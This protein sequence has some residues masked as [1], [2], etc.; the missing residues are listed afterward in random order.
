MNQ[1]ESIAERRNTA[2]GSAMSK[3]RNI[4]KANGVNRDSLKEVR[5]VLLGLA[6][7]RE[8]F[9]EADFPS[10][11]GD[12]LLY[13]LSEDEDDRFALYLSTG[14]PGRSSP[15][16]NHTTWAVIVGIEGEE[17]NRMY[18]RVDDGSEPGR[19]EVRMRDE[20]VVKE[21]TGICFMPDDIH[22]I[23]V[24][25]EVP[26]RNFHMYGRSLEHLPERI[27]FDTDKGTYAVFPASPGIRK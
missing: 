10:T 2:V 24:V 12:P 8:L 13:L 5:E 3:I 11:S 16:H 4:E 14:L 17:Q 27:Q 18:E 15:P 22:S 23:H 25:S 26:T 20:F 21:G 7:K 6:A 9:A 1:T 19:G